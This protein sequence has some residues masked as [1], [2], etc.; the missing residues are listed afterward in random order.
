[1]STPT[2]L[3][4][5]DIPKTTKKTEGPRRWAVWEPDPRWA[6]PLEAAM[7]CYVIALIAS[8][9]AFSI[10]PWTLAA[11][12]IAAGV[13]GAGRARKAWP[14]AEFGDEVRGAM[15]AVAILSGVA[16]GAWLV[17][18]C[19]TSPL[20]A[21]GWLVLGVIWFGAWYAHLRTTAPKSAAVI[22]EAHEAAQIQ[23]ATSTWT[24][25]LKA[26][27]LPLK[28]VETRPTRA[29]YVIGVEPIDAAKPVSF[30]TLRAKLPELTVKA[31]ALLAQGGTAVR[32]GDIRVE[33]T[34]VAHVHLIHV[35]TKHVLSQSIPYEPV[36]EPTTIADPIDFA[37]YE[38]GREV[39]VT[40]G[41]EHGGVN[42][43]IVGATGGGKS[44]LANC[45]IGRVGECAD[46]LVGVVA[47][48]K[49]V[50][51][52]YPWIKPWLEGKA[53]RPG[54][55][56]VAGQD[57]KRVL[58]MLAAIYRFVRERN[59]GLSNESTHTATPQAPAIVLFVEE[60]G[61]MAPR[62]D[63]ILTHDNQKVGF[64]Q[65]LHMICK[66]DRSAQVSVIPMNQ[67]DLYGALGDFGSEIARNTPLR[68]CLKTLAPQDGMSVL[69]GLTQGY[70]DTSKLRHNSMLVQ[71]SIEDP[72]VMPAKSYKLTADDVHPVAIR[73]AAW[74]P[75]IEPA[76]AAL[77]G[78]TWTNRWDASRLPELVAAAHKD[79]LEWPVGLPEDAI[80]V[81]LRELLEH[82]GPTDTAPPEQ[83]PPSGEF[84]DAEAGVAEL[85][86]I[87]DRIGTPLTLPEPLAA[88]MALLAEPQAPRDFIPTRQL[89]ILLDRAAADAE[90]GELTKAAQKLGRELST[91]DGAIRSVQR[92]NLMGY[93]VPALKK[94]AARLARG[95][96]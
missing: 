16:A 44:V 30:D 74:R 73:N 68:I 62:K 39:A 41:G 49:L 11:V 82:H 23:A 81:E 9:D 21:L 7:W 64:S 29:G 12:G 37:L 51:L 34:S 1:M 22:V 83:A 61:D 91:I 58:E 50:P 69:P 8:V 27:G 86:A 84:P 59:D 46:A 77:V 60:A 76:L 72:R 85:T 13:V 24:D 14:E 10:P 55:D 57:P 20:R 32:A 88:V 18:A 33:E 45:L 92:G 4:V 28:I 42:G 96:A 38:D 53:D 52:T 95:E 80:D 48:S 71:P 90:D 47:S 75:D 79:G 15:V 78:D 87:A 19:Y 35:C 26:A 6:H 17:Y 67:M 70:A 93:D 2:T 89:A 54:I 5:D 63:T 31:S 66:E 25:I 36:D 43:K 56:F 65:L 3:T 94:V 40:F